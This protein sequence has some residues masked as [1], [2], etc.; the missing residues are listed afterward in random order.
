MLQTNDINAQSESFYEHLYASE[1]GS[2]KRTRPLIVI[3][4]LFSPKFAIEGFCSKFQY[5]RLFK[6]TQN[7]PKF[8]HNTFFLQ[9]PL[10]KLTEQQ[11]PNVC[12]VYKKK[13]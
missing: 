12:I 3:R 5:D 1:A 7:F 8:L 2:E 11:K 6:Y 13:F 4:F 10:T 9:S